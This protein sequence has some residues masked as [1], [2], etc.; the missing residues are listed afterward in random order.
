MILLHLKAFCLI[1]MVSYLHFNY[2]AT[3][4]RGGEGGRGR[5]NK[6]CIVGKYAFVGNKMMNLY[7]WGGGQEICL[8]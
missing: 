7:H 3:E 8:G 6:H 1:I 2:H 5:K 4:R